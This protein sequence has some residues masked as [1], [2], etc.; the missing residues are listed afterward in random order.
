MNREFD[1]N[2]E[3]I[4][5]KVTSFVNIFKMMSTFAGLIF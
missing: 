1:N 3:K 4:Q 2:S 5:E